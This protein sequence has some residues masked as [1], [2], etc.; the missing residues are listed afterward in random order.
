MSAAEFALPCR[1]AAGIVTVVHPDA[2]AK[3]PVVDGRVAC[4]GTRR[5]GARKPILCQARVAIY[6]EAGRA[7]AA[8]VR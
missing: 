3:S 2:V 6:G 5:Y 7:V 1:G 8:G 4:R